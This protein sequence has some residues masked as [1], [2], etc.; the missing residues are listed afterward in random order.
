MTA[1][2]HPLEWS[3]IQIVRATSGRVL[4]GDAARPFTGIAIDS[5][6]IAQG[7]LFVAIRG[8]VHDGHDFLAAVLDAGVTGILVEEQR[9][10]D[11]LLERCRRRGILCVAVPDTIQA[12]GKL[13]AYNR[14]RIPL[15]VAAI[16]GSNGKTSTRRMTTAVLRQR[17]CT[18][19]TKGNFNNEIGVP[20]TLFRLR[21]EHQWAVVEMGMNHPGEIGRLTAI[22]RP[23]IGVITNVAAAHLEGVGSIEGVASAKAELVEGLPAGATA[24]LNG[25]DPMLRPLADRTPNRVCRFGCTAGND[26]RA[27]KVSADAAGTAFDLLLPDS[28]VP[29]RLRTPGE[30]MVSNALAA[31][32]VGYLAGVSPEQIRDALATFEPVEG[33]LN[34]VHL[35]GGIGLIDDTYN[36]NPSSMQAAFKTAANLA[37]GGRVILVTGD[38][39]E[40]GQHAQDLHRELGRA[41]ARIR[42]ERIYLYGD[43]AEHVANG[44]LAGGYPAEKVMVGSREDILADLKKRLAPGDWVLVKGSRAM[45]M[46]KVAHGLMAWRGERRAVE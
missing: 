14:G 10:I 44:A 45:Q 2:R 15:S 4:C 24:V 13:A 7:E 41:A 35:E 33:R 39:R 9:K 18:L 30:F 1:Q 46:E 42:P 23:D 38:M 12:L 3:G 40:L 32:A 37:S 36:A 19:A 26:V 29:V 21:P 6:S 25:D 5:R 22:C 11:A 20:L 8:E 16:T 27:E 31:A 28:R 43:F 17:Y 34:I